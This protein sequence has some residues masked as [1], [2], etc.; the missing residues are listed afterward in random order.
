MKRHTDRRAR[1]RTLINE[2]F[3]GI[4]AHFAA[5]VDL[6][7]SYVSRL[8]REPDRKGSANLGERMV[9]K[10]EFALGIEGYF[11]TPAERD[12]ARQAS[13]FPNIPPWTAKDYE[14]LNTYIREHPELSAEEI[15]LL[16]AY[17]RLPAEVKAPV[18]A[19]VKS[20]A[21][22]LEPYAKASRL[23]A[24]R[25]LAAPSTRKKSAS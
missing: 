1:L 6:A 13:A 11:S 4:A 22:A 24:V 19:G 3:D 21:R 12:V 25:A 18:V 2:R 14:L 17:Q 9:E 23:A 8:L 5:A 20:L 15:G 10:I 7:P 16:S